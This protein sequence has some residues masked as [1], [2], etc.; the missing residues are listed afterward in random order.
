MR[1]GLLLGIA[2]LGIAFT[3]GT[4]RAEKITGVLID[5]TC[6]AKQMSKDDPQQAAQ[7]HPKSCAM[8]ESCANS[9]FALISGK[10]MY[11]IDTASNDKVKDYLGK[12][13]NSTYVTVDATGGED[14]LTL[15]SINAGE[16]GGKKN[17]KK[18]AE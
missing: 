8:K 1:N 4:A 14:K 10:K 2:A 6:G 16:G 18:K 17:K 13:E 11:K 7:G 12:T 9:G 15:N 3:A 5:Q